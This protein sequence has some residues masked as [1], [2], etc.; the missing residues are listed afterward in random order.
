MV[1]NY[2][3]FGASLETGGVSKREKRSRVSYAA[4]C[5]KHFQFFQVRIF[6][7]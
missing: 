2:D 6:Q 7:M 4:A 5:G 3:A 1:W